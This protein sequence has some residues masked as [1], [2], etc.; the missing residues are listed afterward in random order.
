MEKI[1]QR[2]LYSNHFYE[3]CNKVELNKQF[4]E[5][6]KNHRYFSDQMTTVEVLKYF[7]IQKIL[8]RCKLLFI[9]FIFNSNFQSTE[10]SGRNN[11]K[12]L[13]IT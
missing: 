6:L 4:I 2:D 7:R 3:F 8:I 1:T 11:P 5:G 9:V 13:Y 12:S 10:I